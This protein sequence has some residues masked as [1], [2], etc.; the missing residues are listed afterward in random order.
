[1]SEEIDWSQWPRTRKLLDPRGAD[2]PSL[3]REHRFED[4]IRIRW[5]GGPYDFAVLFVSAEPVRA[6]GWEGWVSLRG[7][8]VEPEGPEHRTT[9]EFYCRPA[10]GEPDAYEMLPMKKSVG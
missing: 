8:V 2:E 4:R 5:P 10:E 3:P 9:R 6:A 1:M 7:L